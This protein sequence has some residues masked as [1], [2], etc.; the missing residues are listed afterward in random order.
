M[1]LQLDSWPAGL[2]NVLLI[3]F[4]FLISWNLLPFSPL[5]VPSII[6]LHLY[7]SMNQGA[8]LYL[9]GTCIPLQ[10]KVHAVSLYWSWHLF[11]LHKFYIRIGMAESWNLLGSQISME[12]IRATPE[13]LADVPGSHTLAMYLPIII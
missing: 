7:N 8:H 9:I 12:T 11:F 4:H 2:F 6:A 1:L 5:L 10:H 13:T 3:T